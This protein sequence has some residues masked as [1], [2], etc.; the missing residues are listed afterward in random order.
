[1]IK[2]DIAVL[3]TETNDLPRTAAGTIAN[4]QQ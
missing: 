3:G 4:C 1:M 2:E